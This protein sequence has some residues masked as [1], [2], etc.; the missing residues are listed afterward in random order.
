M[1]YNSNATTSLD[2]NL[3]PVPGLPIIY[4]H[5]LPQY[6]HFVVAL[7]NAIICVYVIA[8]MYPCDKTDLSLS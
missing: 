8:I 7:T 5:V 1:R 2:N 4:I 6:H 3:P